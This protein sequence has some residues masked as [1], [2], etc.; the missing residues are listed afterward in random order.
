MISNKPGLELL[1]HIFIQEGITDMVISPGSRNAP[2]MLTFPE[3]AEFNIH[4]IIDE[5]SAGFFALGLAQKSR[6]PVV[7]NCT[8]GTALLNYAP[9]IAEAYYQQIPLIVLSADRPLYLI[10]QGDGQAIRQ[11]DVYH[12]FI[13][14]S[15]QLPE[16]IQSKEDSESYQRLVFEAIDAGQRPV[17]GPVHINVPLDEPIYDLKEKEELSLIPFEKSMIDSELSKDKKLELIKKW[18]QAE[19]KLLI[20]GQHL[21]DQDINGIL[22]KLSDQG[23]V[24][25]TESSS[26]MHSSD[27]ISHIDQ[28]LTQVKDKNESRLFPDLVISL[29][30]HIVSKKIKAWL[31]KEQEYEHWHISLDSK[32]PNTFFHLKEHI[33]AEESAVLSLFLNEE[34]KSS[35]YHRAWIK[36]AK[37]AQKLHKYYLS[38]IPFS[39]LMVYAELQKTLTKKAQLHFAN[40][41]PIRYSQFFKFNKDLRID[42]NRGVSGIDGSVSSALGQ[43]QNCKEQ[44]IIISGDLSFFY[45]SNALWNNYIHPKFKIILINNG[46]GGIFRFIDGPLNSGK[47]DLF[48]TPHQRV[49]RTLAMEAGMEYRMCIEADDLSPSIKE[50]INSPHSQLLEIFTPREV[51]DIVLKE[52]FSFLRGE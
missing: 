48:E 38:N 21:P 29:G 13:R 34:E 52:Y 25:M 10:D 28:A 44:T 23:I 33:Q 17:L 39:D 32:A 31:R 11:Q 50:L 43:S 30:G 12:N 19:K 20:I 26:N 5:R 15:V 49:A 41:T 42:C 9:A 36:I 6:R 3:Y 51:N 24:I 40:S 18:N 7:L 22:N 35:K 8:S 37:Q 2:M 4:S 16:N 45:D 46:G 27:F 47:I 1:A 14:K